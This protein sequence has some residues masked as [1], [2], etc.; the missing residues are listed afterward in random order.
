VLSRK[1]SAP[2]SAAK[3]VPREETNGIVQPRSAVTR[4]ICSIGMSDTVAQLMPL[5]A[6]TGRA[7][8]FSVKCVHPGQS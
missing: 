2:Q 7:A 6:S 1:P 8:T 5:P 4:W 3:L